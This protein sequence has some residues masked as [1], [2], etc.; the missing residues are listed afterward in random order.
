[1]SSW[2]QIQLTTNRTGSWMYYIP[3][4][5]RVV[6][7]A[8]L[9]TMDRT[10]SFYRATRMHS[11]DYAVARCPF[12]CPSVCP[13]HSSML[14]TPLNISLFFYHQVAPPFWFVRTKQYGGHGMQGGMKVQYTTQMHT[15]MQTPLGGVNPRGSSWQPLMWPYNILCNFFLY[16]SILIFSALLWVTVNRLY[17]SSVQQNSH[18][19]WC[20]TAEKIRFCI[21]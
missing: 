20:C 10:A 7:G 1:M 2:Q 9:Q 11:A 12:V 21:V 5:T 8:L 3:L 4:G 18:R 15:F 19:L 6:S 17:R 16:F 14:S 13:S